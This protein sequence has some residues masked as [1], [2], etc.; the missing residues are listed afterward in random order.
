MPNEDPEF[1]QMKAAEDPFEVTMATA[2]RTTR[3]QVPDG[4]MPRDKRPK[5]ENFSTLASSFTGQ[6]YH[7]ANAGSWNYYDGVG[8]IHVNEELGFRDSHCQCCVTAKW[9]KS[10]PGR[11]TFDGRFLS[12]AVNNHGWVLDGYDSL[13]YPPG[14]AIH[15]ATR[16]L[17]ELMV[18]TDNLH[19]YFKECDLTHRW[20]HNEQV[21]KPAVPDDH[22]RVLNYINPKKFHL[23]PEVVS[24]CPRCNKIWQGA[25]KDIFK[26]PGELCPDH[27]LV[28]PKCHAEVV[29]KF[30]ILAHDSHLYPKPIFT[31]QTRFLERKFVGGD[32]P[33]KAWVHDPKLFAQRSPMPN[34]RLFGVE[35]E[36]EIRG[37]NYRDTR[38]PLALK[39][40]EVM[41]HDFV[42]IKHDGSLAGEKPNGMGGQKGFEIVSAPADMDEH[43]KRWKL[44][45]D[46]GIHGKLYAW[47]SDLCGMHVHVNRDSLTKLQIG[48]MLV[49]ITNPFNKKFVQK[50]AGRTETAYCRFYDKRPINALDGGNGR[51]GDDG[52]DGRRQAINQ[53]N[54]NTIEFRIFRGTI[55][56]RHIIRNIEFVDA[57]CDF[58]HPGSR[59]FKELTDYRFFIKFID[60]NRKKWPLLAEWMAVHDIIKMGK[61]DRRKALMAKL[62]LQPDRTVGDGESSHPQVESFAV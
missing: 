19:S 21:I 41:G 23:F 34:V 61:I 40:K 51:A 37:K 25:K 6:V 26:N 38:V 30:A 17:D 50:I 4:A 31:K 57:C 47:D 7:G 9:F 1:I 56:S 2:K 55:R 22:E 44:L 58:C 16:G 36:V 59:S 46:S 35:C 3:R 39:V 48:R 49:F 24:S 15:E 42:I 43:K 45:E 13:W 18:T 29:Q 54:K 10:E 33:A 12:H 11:C 14:T 60:S 5:V 28:C 52:D 32:D 53:Q 8:W 20:Y 27:K 62:T